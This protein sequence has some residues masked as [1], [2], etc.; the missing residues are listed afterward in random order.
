MVTASFEFHGKLNDFL[1]PAHRHRVIRCAC[2]E[3]ATAKHMIEVLGI[4]HTEIGLIEVNKQASSL[5]YL[6]QDG[7][8]V[9]V[10]PPVF[11]IRHLDA[12]SPHL[13]SLH[14]LADAHLGGLARLLRMAGFD[15]LYDNTFRD[16]EIV[17]IAAGQ[18]R[19]ILTRDLEL[20]KRRNV[21]AGCYV[22]CQHPAGQMEEVVARFGLAQQ[23][24][25]FT[26]CLHCNAP[27]API[28]KAAVL[29]CLPPSVQECHTEFSRCDCC[30]RVYWKGS[31][32]RRMQTMLRTIISNAENSGKA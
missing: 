16:E 2:A 13:A 28:D 31:H 21:L 15:T 14:F 32:W 29:E 6:L 25:P 20:L 8:H 7:D 17:R 3:S 19:I 23:A 11:P 10:T 26:L 1:K 5:A 30:K 22:R 24:R 4:P 12:A 9:V 18:H 27:L